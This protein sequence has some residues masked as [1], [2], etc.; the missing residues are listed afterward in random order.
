MTTSDVLGNLSAS[1]AWLL[2]SFAGLGNE[3]LTRKGTVGAWSIKDTL[4]HVAAWECIV[5]GFLPQRLATG[6]PPEVL[7]VMEEHGEDAANAVELAERTALTPSELLEELEQAR[8]RLV[9]Y[10]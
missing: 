4:G 9:T 6:N 5:V 7:E 2:A 8:A 1:R 10:I 3:Q